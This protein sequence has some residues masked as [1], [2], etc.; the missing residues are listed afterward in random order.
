MIRNYL[1]VLFQLV[2]ALTIALGGVA[3]SIILGKRGRAQKGKDVAYECGKDTLGAIQPRFSVKFYLV[4]MIF[5]LF[6]IEVIFMYPWAVCFRDLVKSLGWSV[7]E[8]M[9]AFVLLLEVGH[10]YAYKKGVFDWNK[11]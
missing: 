11:R 9:V 6:D 3:T 5:I 4:A 1:P 2:V 7:L 10:L 8:A